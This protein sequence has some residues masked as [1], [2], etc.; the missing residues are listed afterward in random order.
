MLVVTRK[1]GE[2]IVIGADIRV[3]VAAIKGD[4]VRIGIQAPP[5]VTVDREEIHELRVAGR[6]A[7]P[8]L[9]VVAGATANGVV[10]GASG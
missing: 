9:I 5:E 3:C 1:A 6:P 2:A 10:H 8:G 7:P 4:R